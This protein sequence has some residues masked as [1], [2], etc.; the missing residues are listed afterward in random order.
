MTL[1]MLMLMMMVGGATNNVMV[2]R[3][4][5]EHDTNDNSYDNVN[6]NSTGGTGDN[7]C[8]DTNEI[9]QNEKTHVYKI[10]E[11]RKEEGIL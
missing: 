6:D 10:D 2:I 5:L 1:E 3:I 4:E 11:K 9:N 8:S 7:D